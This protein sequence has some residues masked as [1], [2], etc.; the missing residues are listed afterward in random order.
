M[1]ERSLEVFQ[2][3]DQSLRDGALTVTRKFEGEIET[4]PWLVVLD[5]LD[6]AVELGGIE[7]DGEIGAS[8][9]M[10]WEEIVDAKEE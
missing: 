7:E 6:D 8:A 4:V 2:N 3:P 1:F 10:T 9:F 5:I